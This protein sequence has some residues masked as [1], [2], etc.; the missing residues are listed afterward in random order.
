MPLWGCVNEGSACTTREAI[1]LFSLALAPPGRS[2]ADRVGRSSAES[3]P[4]KPDGEGTGLAVWT[5]H[6]QTDGALVHLCYP[7]PGGHEEEVAW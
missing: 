2:A 3:S 1:I 6:C 7:S 5:S 4:R